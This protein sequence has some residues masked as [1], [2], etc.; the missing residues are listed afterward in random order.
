[1]SGTGSGGLGIETGSVSSQASTNWIAP[2]GDRR[3]LEDDQC[4]A[5]LL[6]IHRLPPDRDSLSTP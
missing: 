3:E 4:C 1:M 5:W 2:E 6:L